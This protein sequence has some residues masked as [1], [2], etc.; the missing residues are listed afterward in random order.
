MRAKTKYITIARE[1]RPNQ[2]IFIASTDGT[3]AKFRIFNKSTAYGLLIFKFYESKSR[4]PL[5]QKRRLFTGGFITTFGVFVC[6][7]RWPEKT[8]AWFFT[9]EKK[10]T[11]NFACKIRS[12]PIP[13]NDWFP[14]TTITQTV[15]HRVEWRY[16]KM[17]TTLLDQ[18]MSILCFL[19]HY[20]LAA[21]FPLEHFH[22][23]L[24]C[25]KPYGQCHLRTT[26]SCANTLSVELGLNRTL[27]ILLLPQSSSNEK[28]YLLMHLVLSYNQDTVLQRTL[29]NM[30]HVRLWRHHTVLRTDFI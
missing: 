27:K 14:L 3:S 25:D 2:S 12:R 11:I 6:W 22:P 19:R 17:E 8:Q 24:C 4:S 18:N 1:F 10:K 7:L 5:P 13:V 9:R 28:Y 29:Q 16:F 20:Q 26:T 15:I 21:W 23:V 30:I